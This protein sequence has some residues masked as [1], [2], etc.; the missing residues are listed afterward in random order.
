MTRIDVRI[1]STA[2]GFLAVILKDIPRDQQSE[3]AFTIGRLI[4]AFCHTT[5][6]EAFE[7][8]D[9]QG[10][11]DLGSSASESEEDI[12]TAMRMAEAIVEIKKERGDCLSRDLLTKGFVQE[13]IDRHWAMARALAAVKLNIS[14]A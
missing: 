5:V 10:E 7:S 9:D 3:R 11:N 13:E 8:A 14:D 12:A 1:L 6:P 2:L 4:E